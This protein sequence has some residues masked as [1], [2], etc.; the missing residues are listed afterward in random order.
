MS[1]PCICLKMVIDKLINSGYNKHKFFAFL[2]ER[3]EHWS[4]A[5]HSL[6][7]RSLMDKVAVFGTVDVGPIPTEG[8]GDGRRVGI[9]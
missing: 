9:M 1:I 7:P 2:A 5:R 8:I 4:P 3:L 6:S